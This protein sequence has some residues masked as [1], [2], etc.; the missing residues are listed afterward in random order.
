MPPSGLCF[1]DPATLIETCRRWEAA[2]ADHLVFMIQARETVAQQEVL[3]SL[4]LFA[5]EVMPHFG[6]QAPKRA[7]G[8]GR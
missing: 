6:A 2:G 1:G 8:G 3:D 7:A 4:R 5:R